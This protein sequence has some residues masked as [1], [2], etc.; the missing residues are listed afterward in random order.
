MEKDRVHKTVFDSVAEGLLLID[1]HDY[2][3]KLRR[4][5]RFL[6]TIHFALAQRESVQGMR[7]SFC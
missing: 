1:E 7:M 6:K 3:V 5:V 4:A 2:D